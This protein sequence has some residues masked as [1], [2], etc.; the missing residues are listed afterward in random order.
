MT[1]LPA[2]HGPDVLQTFQSSNI[3]LELP[4]ET[5]AAASENEAFHRGSRRLPHRSSGQVQVP[6]LLR[7][8]LCRREPLIGLKLP[9]LVGGQPPDE[10]HV[11]KDWL[12]L[13][14]FSLRKR[15]AREA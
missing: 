7:P 9:L 4:T 10:R 2:A 15:S 6:A 13:L 11:C 5:P 14:E 8:E 3:Q 12:D 1:W